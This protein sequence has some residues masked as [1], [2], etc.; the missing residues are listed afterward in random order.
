MML[1]SRVVPQFDRASSE[2]AGGICAVSTSPASKALYDVSGSA[3][4]R[5]TKQHA[6]VVTASGQFR[7]P[8][9]CGSVPSKSTR[10]SS[11]SISTAAAISRSPSAASTVSVAVYL[12]SGMSAI[13]ARVRR[14]A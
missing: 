8:P 7:F 4:T 2:R 11:P 14:S 5:R 3:I 13:A 9:C 12:P 1:T 10:T 6:E